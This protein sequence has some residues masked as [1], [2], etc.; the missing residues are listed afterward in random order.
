M[1]LRNPTVIIDKWKY[2]VTLRFEQPHLCVE[3]RIFP[4][5]L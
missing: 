1:H 3:D 2:L 4:S 5:G